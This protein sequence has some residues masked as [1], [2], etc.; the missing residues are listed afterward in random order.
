M[1]TIYYIGKSKNSKS[2]HNLNKAKHIFKKMKVSEIYTSN[3][4]NGYMAYQCTDAYS[5]ILNDIINEKDKKFLDK[6]YEEH[7]YPG[8]VN[9]VISTVDIPFNKET[10]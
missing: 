8:L 7:C 5:L 1:E 6:Y 3:E 9:T 4:N 10:L 2:L